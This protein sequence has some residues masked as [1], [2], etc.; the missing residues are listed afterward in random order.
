MRAVYQYA[1]RQACNNNNMRNP[2]LHRKG[3][4]SFSLPR[5]CS[6][7]RQ[8]PFLGAASPCTTLRACVFFINSLT[9]GLSCTHPRCLWEPKYRSS[10]SWQI[11]WLKKDDSWNVKDVSDQFHKRFTCRYG[12]IIVAHNICKLLLRIGNM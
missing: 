2:S 12:M 3:C 6:P 1:A 8:F 9:F 7:P 4:N 10:G 5:S 11:L